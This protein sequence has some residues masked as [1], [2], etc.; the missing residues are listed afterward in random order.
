MCKH[1]RFRHS[2]W[3]AGPLFHFLIQISK[4]RR[5]IG[6]MVKN[7]PH[8]K[9]YYTCNT[10]LSLT[11]LHYHDV[12]LT[13]QIR[14]IFNA[15]LAVCFFLTKNDLVPARLAGPWRSGKVVA[16]WPWGHGFKSWKQPL[17][18]MQG[19][20]TYIRAKVTGPFPRPCASRSYVHRAALIQIH[21][22]PILLISNTFS[23][24][25]IQKGWRKPYCWKNFY[26]ITL[27]T[28]VWIYW[29]GK[30]LIQQ[31]MLTGY[32]NVLRI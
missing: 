27:R 21:G 3:P 16:L 30:Q 26:T 4:V 24:F 15:N 6:L 29:E 10:L 25:C 22:Y 7:L 31:Y 19:N 18:E 9:S 1:S 5:I 12:N 8:E 11:N 13:T 28:T 20:A 17:A 14:V 23:I 2:Q 32:C